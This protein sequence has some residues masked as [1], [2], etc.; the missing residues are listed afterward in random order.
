MQDAMATGLTD[1]D[2]K[3]ATAWGAKAPRS[4]DVALCHG[5]DGVA[6]LSVVERDPRSWTV[7]VDVARGGFEVGSSDDGSL[8]GHVATLPEALAMLTDAAQSP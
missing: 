1:A 4:V 5:D 8:L 2:M 3:L 6:F 7:A